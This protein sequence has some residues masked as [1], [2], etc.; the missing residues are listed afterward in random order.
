[1]R[2]IPENVIDDIRQKSDIVDTVSQYLT[3]TRKG[4]NYLGVCPFHDDHDPSMSVSPD[5]QIYKCFVCG[6]GGN[7]FR[8]IQSIE[9]IS[10]T[11]AVI[12]QAENVHIDLSEYKSSQTQTIDPKKQ[13]AYEL[14]STVQSFTQYTL[15]SEEGKLALNT[16]HERG[17]SDDLIKH[18]G[19]GVAL[20][21]NKIHTFLRAKGYQD[22]EM[23]ANDII[24][25][26]DTIQDVFY[27]RIMF[28]ISDQYGRVIAFTAR[29]L[30]P[31]STVKYINTSETENY[32]KGNHIYNFNN[33]KETARKEGRII[34]CEGVTDVMAFYTAGH[35]NAVAMLG[36]ACT[37]SQVNLLRSV[38]KNVM[39][40]FDGDKAGYEATF[41]IG[42]KL[43]S[44]GF[45]VSVWY[46][47]TGKDPDEVVKT[48]GNKRLNEG[49]ENALGWY[50]FLFTYTIGLYGLTSFEDKKRVALTMIDHLSDADSL[51][52][53]YYLKRVSEKT[54]FDNAIIQQMISEQ[55]KSHP[56]TQPKI[57]YEFI[58]PRYSVSK[59]E[60]ELLKQML[61]SKQAAHEYR[62]KLGFL[63]DPM[64]HELALIILDIYRTRDK[65]EVADLYSLD[66]S[67]E[68]GSFISNIAEDKGV[69][70]Y[71][72]SVVIETIERIQ[73]MMTDKNNRRIRQDIPQKTFNEQLEL[74]DLV[75]KSRRKIKGG[76]NNG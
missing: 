37:D 49:I 2:R 58:E 19:I 39:L 71:K 35:Q 52:R 13:R 14:M 73:A 30:D 26:N 18:F 62:D 15:N 11:D 63:P 74:L 6:A 44:S 64:A 67:A 61:L 29:T 54:G 36:I 41:S 43:V 7:V 9:N 21:N 53:N 27:N 72:Q 5:R 66:L 20:T 12:K 45:K 8:F 4:K 46:N 48:L 56:Q 50:D 24:R 25:I 10:F 69:E 51:E 1:M 55:T 28:P 32:I 33:A 23:L 38:T 68:M 59:P 40:A 17:Y 60:R 76:S 3:L 34:I 47:D 75:M 22:D 70:V 57:D 65:I 16:L 31:N 42:T